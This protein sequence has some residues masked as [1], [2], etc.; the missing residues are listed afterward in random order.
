MSESLAAPAASTD[1]DRSPVVAAVICYV[2]WGL[3]PILFIWAGQAGAQAFEIVAWRTLWSLPCAL[4]LVLVSGQGASLFTIPPKV[5]AA[6]ALSAVL[7]AGNW[8]VY[9]WAVSTGRTISASLGYYLNPLLNMGVGALLFRERIDRA[10]MVAIALAA[11]GVVLQGVALGAFPWVSIALALTFGS[12]GIVRKQAP[13]TAQTGLFVECLLLFLPAA[14]YA[15]L[16]ART[17]HGAFGV[18]PTATLALILGG[19]A[20]VIPLALFAFAARRLSLTLVGFVQ[21]ITPTLQ[22]MVGVESGE[23]LTRLR[24]LSFAFIWAGV[25]VFAGKAWLGSRSAKRQRQA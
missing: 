19:P 14:A 23:P 18:K 8:T 15:L 3:L 1:V 24:I 20:T 5:L 22:F 11:I 12:Y 2:L 16:L 25:M 13:V 4:A 17:G 21:F 7:I 6:L 9:V 10:G